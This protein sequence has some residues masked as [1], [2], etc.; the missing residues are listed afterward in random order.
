MGNG[1]DLILI[2]S[3]C[4]LKSNLE[5]NVPLNFFFKKRKKIKSIEWLVQVRVG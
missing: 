3:S 2:D 5:E 4:E 1:N